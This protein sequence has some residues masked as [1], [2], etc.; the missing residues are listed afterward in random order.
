M[1]EVKLT[2]QQH[3]AAT[4]GG[5]ACLV[6]A[7]AGSGKT[8]V[9][10]QRLMGKIC[11]PAI[12]ADITDFLVITYTRAAAAELKSRI[13]REINRRIRLEPENRHLRRQAVL[14]LKAHI[15]TIHGF[16]TE[17][18]REHAQKID[19]SPDFRVADDVECTLI[20][21]NVLEQVLN[22]KY[23]NI[24]SDAQFK[25]FAEL[26]VEMRGDKKLSEAVLDAYEKLRSH[27]NPEQ[28]MSS[29][30]ELL[31]LDGV[32]DL[33]ETLW[34]QELIE[35]AKSITEHC[36]SKMKKA[37]EEMT[38][39]P[40][41][42][43]AYGDSFQI[44]ISDMENLRRE[45]E[46]GWDAAY[47]AR[48]VR[49]PSARIRGYD[50]IKAVRTSCRDL[51]K[52]EAE[53]FDGPS[54]DLLEDMRGVAA[55]SCGL[56]ALL[57][58]FDEGYE[59][60]KRR[61]GIVDFPDQEHLALKLLYDFEKGAPTDTAADV[62]RR[63]REILVDEYQDVNAVQELIF[64]SIT[65]S[66]RN[67]FMVGDVKQSIY[68]FRMADP[69]IFLAKY[70]SFRDYAEDIRE[71]FKV[72]LPTNFRSEKSILDAVNYIFA[73]LMSKSFGE[74]D[75][76]QREYLNA[77]ADYPPCE[78]SCVEYD[79]LE[80][81]DDV[82]DKTAAEAD[83]IAG[84]IRQL[85]ESGTEAYISGEMR[86]LKYSDFTILL[87]SVKNKAWQYA[88]ALDRLGIPAEIP[89]G[90]NFFESYEISLMMS[91]LSVIDNPRQ[92]IPLIAVLRS[93]IYRF[94][95]DELV[96]IR[97]ANRKSS[98]YD[99]L[100]EYSDN[101]AKCAE[102]V[103]ALDA[104]RDDALNLPADKLI[105]KLYRETGLIEL[106]TLSEGGETRQNNLLALS[107]LARQFEANGYKGLFKFVRQLNMMRDNGMSV[108]GDTVSGSGVK[109]MSIHKSKGLEFPVVIL[110]DTT[111]RFNMQDTTKPILFHEKLGIGLYRRDKK[112]RIKYPTIAR[113]A[114]SRRIQS[115]TLS[116]ELRVLYVAL[117]RAKNRLIMV[118]SVKDSAK[119]LAKY[120]QGGEYPVPPAVL[121]GV[122]S[123]AGWLLLTALTRPESAGIFSPDVPEYNTAAQQPWNMRLVKYSPTDEAVKKQLP[124]QTDTYDSSIIPQIEERIS[125]V[126]PH[127]ESI[128]LPS[129]LTATELKGRDVDR[130]ASEDAETTIKVSRKI[131][132]PALSVSEKPLT[133]SERGTALHQTMQ[134]INYSCCS[135]RRSMELE[136]ERLVK[137]RFI[138]Q[139]QADSVDTEKIYTF[140]QSELGLR[141]LNS[142]H[143]KR[144][145]KFSVLIPANELINT[146]ADDEILFQGVV[147]CFF[148]ENGELV[149]VDFKTDHLTDDNL[150]YKIQQ[151]TGQLTSYAKALN[152]MTGKRVAGAVLYFFS[153]DMAVKII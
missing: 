63:Y 128:Q 112:R 129:K 101:N 65:K 110:A 151:Y 140:F 1:S 117:T 25:A 99:A 74:M 32:C 115:E 6:S 4:A 142:K 23:E 146:Q 94:T 139:K 8:M 22:T 73:N 90:S 93:P 11:D 98:I 33:S 147:D 17:L 64:S 37:Y 57:R 20:K 52:K 61:R 109:I 75:Y 127:K 105:W 14:C 10:V 134:Y 55:E 96:E 79:I 2:P 47:N 122:Q 12:N 107:E 100:L 68:R 39:Y 143:V 124:E 106:V 148:E 36:V 144:E 60:E 133:A 121:E 43:K 70:T 66:G 91:L 137:Q 71:P 56:Y 3:T 136:I 104:L 40:D 59:K 18:L 45:L 54:C 103:N 145:F 76:T 80:T 86:R 72:L 130:E 81:G 31:T 9:L 29:Q 53:L 116:E 141:I 111:H 153:R 28:W 21:S 44:S 5:Q 84:R 88:Y 49:F 19:I 120:W 35:H 150:E 138:T 46:R 131:R 113:R 13:L 87:R 118:S 7:A 24:E 30:E 135:D 152:M 125:Y 97:T 78:D 108:G 85:V 42:L 62:S 50:D 67:L 82:T 126:Y 102:F 58:A 92:D 69:T 16:C 48:E 114:V 27:P 119:E 77:G 51:M 123:Y 26:M 95:A 34:G 38:Q 83:F 41:M 149:I 132:K 89:T 15:S